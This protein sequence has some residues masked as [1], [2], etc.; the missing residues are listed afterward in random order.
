MKRMMLQFMSGNFVVSPQDAIVLLDIAS[1]S[2]AVRQR[3]GWKGP[4]IQSADQDPFVTAAQIVDY[5][6]LALPE[7]EQPF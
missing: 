3:D 4:F 7:E 6:P 2:V 1:R 5:E